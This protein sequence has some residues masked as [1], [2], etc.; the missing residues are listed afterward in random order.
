LDTFETLMTEHRLIERVLAGLSSFADQV[1]RKE[2][3]NG[4]REL[5]HF[6]SFIRGYADARHHGKEEQILFEAMVDFGFPREGGPVGVML[7]E[8]DEGRALV[9]TLSAL[10]EQ[11]PPWSDEDRER[12]VSAASQFVDLLRQ[13]IQKEDQILYPM[14]ESRL[15][16]ETLAQLNEKCRRF[17]EAQAASEDSAR[18]LR[19][20]DELIARFAPEAVPRGEQD[21]LRC[22]T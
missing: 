16:P 5:A 20:A 3:T 17:E 4:H 19:L 7:R 8:H 10:A 6:V 22:C 18:L 15:P 9:R 12:L 11:A 21:L 1:R 13:H 2:E 14:A